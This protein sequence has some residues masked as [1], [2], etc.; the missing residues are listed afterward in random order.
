MVKRYIVIVLKKLNNDD[1]YINAEL[2]ETVESVPDTHI[3]LTTGKKLT[4]KDTVEGVIKK[5]IE[6]KKSIHQTIKVVSVN[7]T[8]KQPAE[9]N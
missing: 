9:D 8:N 1:I 7:K 6:Y 5:V 2:I 4:V 3:S